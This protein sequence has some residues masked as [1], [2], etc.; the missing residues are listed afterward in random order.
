VHV[1]LFDR[2]IVAS[3]LRGVEENGM[4]ER[5]AFLKSSGLVLAALLMTVD[6]ASA[7]DIA[8]TRALIDRGFDAQYSRIEAIYKD[9]HSHPEL[10]FQETRT[11]AKLAAEMRA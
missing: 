11:A 2:G 4:S 8:G 7:A 3:D 1:G 10:S 5:V 6:V 9:I